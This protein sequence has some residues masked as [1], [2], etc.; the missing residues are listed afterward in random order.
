MEVY[1]KQCLLKFLDYY[2][3]IVDDIWG[4]QS[5]LA[6]EAFQRDYQLQVDG[7]FGD[8][9][10]KRILEVIATGEK[11]P[12]ADRPD[13]SAPSGD[14]WAEIKHFK[15]ADPGIRC[16]CHRCGGFPVEPSERLMR[17]ADEIR[18][19]FGKPMIP[20]STV[21]CQAHN[22]ELSGSSSTSRHMRGLA[23]D[24]AIQGVPVGQVLAYTQ[25]LKSRGIIHYTY[26]MT[27]T[28]YVHIDVD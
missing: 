14:F 6:T 11:P 28:G 13:T 2:T 1:K 10:L 26:E 23:M 18:E 7:V 20:S 5:R 27:G 9:T 17:V 3:G 19:H 22:A 12:V 21:R 4:D 16:P 8:G 25:Q 15:R 24:F